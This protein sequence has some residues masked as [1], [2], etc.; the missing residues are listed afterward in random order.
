[1]ILRGEDDLTTVVLTTQACTL[2]H[3]YCVPQYVTKQAALR[4]GTAIFASIPDGS[5]RHLFEILFSI[6][7]R[8]HELILHGNGKLGRRPGGPISRE[9]FGDYSDDVV[10]RRK[11]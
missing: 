9:V 7:V 3:R 5:G 4:L 10:A 8:K 6:G 2:T 11:F 1:M